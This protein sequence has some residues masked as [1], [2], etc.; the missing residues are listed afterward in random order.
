MNATPQIADLIIQ[1][2][3]REVLRNLG[4]PRSRQPS[5]RVEEQLTRLWEGMGAQLNPRG[6]YQVVSADQIAASGMPRPTHKVGLGICTIGGTLEQRGQTQ[7]DE[8][9]VLEALLMDAFGSAAAEAAA[10]ALNTLLC[11]EAH[12]SG[13]GVH[14]RISPGYGS[15]DVAGQRALFDLM[16]A[17]KVGVSLTAGMMMMPRKS[18]SFVVRMEQGA[19]D[20]RGFRRGCAACAM[21]SCLYRDDPVQE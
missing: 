9:M 20:A 17:A 10:D 18:V 21:E 19:T 15:W 6:I 3:R 14:S 12:A 5:P 7:S 11:A 1:V 2:S 16:P 4:Y 8:G 13:Y